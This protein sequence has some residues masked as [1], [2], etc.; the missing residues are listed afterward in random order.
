MHSPGRP[1]GSG[2]SGTPVAGAYLRRGDFD[3][4]ATLKSGQV[5]RWRELSPYS[6]GSRVF[7]GWIG[8]NRVEVTQQG[9]KLSVCGASADQVE[10][11]FS[12][13]VDLREIAHQIDV[14]EIIHGALG[15]YWGLR[16]IRQDP[17]ECLASFILSSFNNIP[18]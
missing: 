12:L 16:V 13:D 3:L 7:T 10:R 14:D 17:W 5:F 9:P 15:R 1:S 8:A 2:H 4:A 18:A 11:Y 6:N